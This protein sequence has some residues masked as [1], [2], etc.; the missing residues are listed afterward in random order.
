MPS[1]DFYIAL[2]SFGEAAVYHE[3]AS[4]S[5]NIKAV[6]ERTPNYDGDQTTYDIKVTVKAQDVPNVDV[7]KRFEIRSVNYFIKNTEQDG[8]NDDI[9]I[10]ELSKQA[11]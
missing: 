7:N 1:E 5:H 3:T 10:L 4:A 11:V 6:F 2:D 9:L 8:L